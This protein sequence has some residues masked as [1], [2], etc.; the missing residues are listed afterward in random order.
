MHRVLGSIIRVRFRINNSINT[1]QSRL[2]HA[3]L[4]R[5]GSARMCGIAY[6]MCVC[7]CVC[8]H[9]VQL[10]VLF[11]YVLYVRVLATGHR[12]TITLLWDAVADARRCATTATDDELNKILLKSARPQR[13]P[14]PPPPPVATGRVGWQS[15]RARAEHTPAPAL[16]SGQP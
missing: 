5:I 11:I 3:T 12:R 1:S 8:V 7:V 6:T 9:C 4:H 14:L 2:S 13:R 16:V 15:G 10:S